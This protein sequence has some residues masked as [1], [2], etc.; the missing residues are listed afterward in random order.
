[1]RVPA[2]GGVHS[3][4]GRKTEMMAVVMKEGKKW[5]GGSGRIG[6]VVLGYWLG[7]CTCEKKGRGEI[8][9]I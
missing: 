3:N 9:L 6:G 4:N 8:F 5:W 2:D 7:W 1:M